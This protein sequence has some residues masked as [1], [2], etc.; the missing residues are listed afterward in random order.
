MYKIG[1]Y[2]KEITPFLGCS[3]RGYF[4]LRCASDVK[5]KTYAKAVAIEK[6]GQSVILVSIDAPCFNTDFYDAVRARASK[7]TGVDIN[8]VMVTVTHCHTGGPSYVGQFEGANDELDKTYLDWLINAVGDVATLAYMHR[9]PGKIKL[10]IT[11]VEGISFVRNY[12]LK[13]GTVRTNPGRL[14]PDIVEPFGEPDYE[15]P[16]LFLENKKGEKIGLAY[17]FACHQDCVDGT[18]IC[19]DYSCIVAKRMKETYGNDFVSVYFSGTAGNMNHFNVNCEKDAPDHYVKMGEK[20][21]SEIC[22]VVDDAQEICG[23]LKIISDTRIYSTRV[24]DATAVEQAKKDMSKVEIPYGV[25]LDASAPV[26]LFNAL[27][28]RSAY[29]FAMNAKKYH[30]VY[31]QIIKVGK[32]LIF[33]FAGEVFTQFG[34]R[35]REAFPENKCFFI[36]LANQSTF[37]IPPKECYLPDL[38]ESKPASALLCPEDA[39]DLMNSYIDLA[40]RLD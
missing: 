9:Q 32:V 29:R 25:K 36:T 23:D 11:K 8:N 26:E 40:K 4:N 24:P 15:L 1:V 6:D 19:G 31:Q 3:I 34:K 33:A 37:Y 35:I 16:V 17:S 21:Y 10:A 14:N 7:L 22:A 2:E 20:I 5:E 39:E 18:E 27:T 12:L 13:N 30:A 28:A 38:Y